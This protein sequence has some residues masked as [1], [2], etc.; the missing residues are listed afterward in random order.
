MPKRILILNVGSSSVKYSLYKNDS[1]ITKQTIE[2]IG[3][4]NSRIQTY[5]QA[6][7]LIFKKV[8]DVDIIGH[9]VVHGGLSPNPP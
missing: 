9:R 5:A 3:E 2:K 8:G 4:R 1:F 6:I 7:D